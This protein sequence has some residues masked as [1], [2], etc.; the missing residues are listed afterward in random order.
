[1]SEDIKERKYIMTIED[2]QKDAN[3]LALYLDGIDEEFPDLD[4]RVRRLIGISYA[5][6]GLGEVG[7]VQ[8]KIKKIIRDSNGV[9][10]EEA[11]QAISK[12]LGD[13]LWYIAAT[14]KEF[15][16]SMSDVA[17]QNLDKL[18]SRKKRGVLK[19]SGDDR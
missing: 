11:K 17:Q 15:G 1:M 2:Y 10:T 6:L 7:E 8:G 4:P 5:S 12:E 18:F 19:G 3:S 16:L 9:I 13:V 14:C